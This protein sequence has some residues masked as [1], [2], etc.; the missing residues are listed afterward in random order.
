MNTCPAGGALVQFLLI[1]CELS[2]VR[3]PI[4]GVIHL[5][6]TS[7]VNH[8]FVVMCSHCYKERAET[9]FSTAVS[10]KNAGI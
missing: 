7:S 8:C 2:N 5:Q 1:L 10:V 9:L 6:Q 3:T 4:T